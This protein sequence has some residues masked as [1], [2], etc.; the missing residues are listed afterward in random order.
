[1]MQLQSSQ[2]TVRNLRGRLGHTQLRPVLLCLLSI[3]L[4]CYPTWLARSTGEDLGS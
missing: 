1:M 2:P 3:S 4:A